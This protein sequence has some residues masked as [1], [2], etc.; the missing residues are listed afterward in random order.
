[1][2]PR[3]DRLG[4]SSQVGGPLVARKSEITGDLEEMAVTRDTDSSPVTVGKIA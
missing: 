4:Y 2:P 3:E 1:M